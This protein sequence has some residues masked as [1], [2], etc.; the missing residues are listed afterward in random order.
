MQERRKG[1]N[2]RV[3]AGRA[4]MS[5]RTARKYEQAGQLPSQLKEPHSWKTRSDPFE[6]DWPW[7]VSQ[8]ERDPALQGST[9][10]AL[11]AERHPQ[12]YRPTQVRTLQRHIARWKA[13]HGPERDVIFEQ[14]H[15]PG[16]RAQSDFTHMDDLAVT[17]AGV[18]FPHL[19]FHLVLTYSN[20]EAVSLC[21]S[22]SFEALAEGIERC[23]W[24]L[25]GVPAQ[26]RTDHLTAAVRRLNS[27]AREDWTTRYQAL[28]AHYGMQ[29]TWNNTGI[30]HENGD[31]EQSHF[32][33]KEAVDQALRVRGSREFPDRAAYERFVQDLVRKRNATREHRFAI[34]REALHPLPTMPLAP[35]RE[36]RV[37]VSRFSTI[38]VLSNTYSVSSR[39][40][41]SAVLIR[42]RAETLEGY[43]GTS[44]VFILPRLVGKHQ[45]RICYQHL[46]WS[47]V[48]K[49]GAF[50]AY[51]YRD[52]LYPT[53]TFRQAYDRLQAE[54]SIRADHEYVRLLHLAASTSESEVETALALLLELKQ[55]PT[56][57]AVRDLVCVPQTHAIPQIAAPTLD[58]SSYDDLIPSRRAHG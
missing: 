19:Y 26:H 14:H 45:H 9:L 49:P 13:L 41:G 57:A 5:E 42:V 30:A 36:V 53:T 18:A 12:R 1:L 31:V 10:F 16:E 29:P 40:I 28:M 24:Q 17:L 15:T 22:E 34:E 50:A 39:L 4:G 33:F 8:L 55:V 21:F 54:R 58:L 3:A 46:I 25:G 37:M 47:L 11:L 32:R 44:R 27:A 35:C 48:R 51:R 20:V 23:L 52:D 56:F 2:Q 43:V 38:Q 6:E 7:V